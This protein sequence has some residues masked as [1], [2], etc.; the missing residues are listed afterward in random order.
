[1]NKNFCPSHKFIL[2]S[3]FSILSNFISPL[4]CLLA[5]RREGRLKKGYPIGISNG[6]NL[7]K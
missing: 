3:F 7:L 1:M 5:G 6:I 4:P 2:L